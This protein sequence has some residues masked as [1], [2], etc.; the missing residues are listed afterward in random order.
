MKIVKKIRLSNF[1]KFENFEIDFNEKMNILI[2]DNEAGKSSVL[3][4]LDL[5]L[6]GSRGKVETLGIETLLNAQ[7]VERF[8]AGK[9]KFD[10]LP[11]MYVEV[12][13]NEQNNPDLFGK[14]NSKAA[15]CDGLRLTCEP[16]QE[17]SREI[18][19]VLAQEGHN[20]PYEYYSVR[21]ST[22]SDQAY[23]GYSRFVRHLVI[24]S[25]QINNEYATRE[26]TKSIYSANADTVQK[27][28]YQNEYRKHK[29]NFR[30]LVLNELNDKLEE[31]KFSVRNNS[32][33]NL[34]T[35]LVITEGGIPI[36]NKGKGKQC[37]IKTEFALRKNDGIERIDSLLLE[38][39]E[40]HL[41]H[42]NTK[43]LIQRIGSSKTKQIFI[44][45][46]NNLICTRLDL[47]STIMLNSS[48]ASPLVLGALTEDTANFFMKAPDNNILEFILSKKVILVEGDA[49][50]ILIEALY[51]KVVPGGTP[52]ADD[53]HVISVGG[54]SFKRYLELAKILKIR[55]AV[56][57]DND[58]QYQKNCIDGY[59]GHL[60]DH[61][62]VFSD[63][64]DRR[65]TFEV[66]FYQDNTEVCDA[67]FEAG[68][69]TISVQNFMISNK[70]DVAFELLDKR[71]ADLNAPK[72]IQEAIEWVRA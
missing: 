70:A 56:V 23:S 17:Y 48:G 9:K 24:D 22:F 51:K 42:V 59:A 32:K 30:E 34:E 3:L 21:F 8:L 18:F 41:S 39:P 52:E 20:F 35:D 2:G 68:R 11:V 31:Y 15:N 43:K 38:E 57:R 4:A 40:N 54:T 26:Y 6:S 65:H 46:H 33:S 63:P 16:I 5:V 62:K 64:D 1:K 53:V 29:G 61:I 12:F 19:A 60:A 28:R 47:R 69:R 37:L 66:C 45:T 55:T 50:F 49:E 10:D 13:L 14:C 36:D 72:Y 58:G 25:S 7:C 67:L 44:A 71:A 27:Y